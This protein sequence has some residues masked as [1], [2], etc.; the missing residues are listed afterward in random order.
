MNNNSIFII[1]NGIL[2]KCNDD[3]PTIVEIP[4]SVKVIDAYAFKDLTSIAHIKFNSELEEIRHHAFERCRKI[5]TLELNDS[6]KV[7]GNNA[8]YRCSE[9]RSVTGG[10][11]LESIGDEAFGFCSNLYSFNVG[12]NVQ[13]I[14][15]SAFKGCFRMVSITADSNNSY[16]SA[17]DHILF[18][19]D[20]THLLRCPPH[21]DRIEIEIPESVNTI[22]DY[23]FD[24]CDGVQSVVLPSKLECIGKYAFRDCANL[25]EL[26]LGSSIKSVDTTAFDHWST[27][28]EIICSKGVPKEIRK[29]IELLKQSRIKNDFNSVNKSNKL[30][31]VMVTTT[32][33]SESEAI[34]MI[35]SLIEN[36][37]IVSGQISKVKAIYYWVDKI[38]EE[39]EYRI[40]CITDSRK[41]PSVKKYI[42]THHSF[43]VCELLCYP[44]LNTT[45]EFGNWIT[46][47]IDV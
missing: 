21:Y 3:K 47:Y 37:L 43:N 28:L 14:S 41:Y 17:H 16:Y 33:E 18:N 31:Y 23:A 5:E 30:Q 29:Q 35:H 25:R 15:S 45:A 9:L 34:S 38:N 4:K 2:S 19:R 7:I 36:K 11:A 27:E 6:L 46:G 39:E 22:G 26:R 42:T 1:K 13:Y 24:G 8:F 40:S 32:F 12:A 20:K 44:V 10:K